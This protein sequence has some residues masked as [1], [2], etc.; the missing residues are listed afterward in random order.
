MY[1]Y[2]MTNST[3]RVLYTGVTSNLRRRAYQH[4]NGIGKGFTSRYRA[5]TLVWYEVHDGPGSAIQREKQIKAGRRRRK[6]E[7]IRAMN[8]GWRDLYDEL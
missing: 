2:I 1:V 3:R 5:R 7:L 4:R 8:P 6:M